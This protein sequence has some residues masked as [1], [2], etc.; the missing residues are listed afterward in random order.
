MHC[1][2]KNPYPPLT[3]FLTPLSL[4]PPASSHPVRYMRF[5]A[6]SPSEKPWRVFWYGID[7]FNASNS[8]PGAFESEDRE[9]YS[10]FRVRAGVRHSC[11]MLKWKALHQCAREC[12]SFCR[13]STFQYSKSCS[14]PVPKPTGRSTRHLTCAC[15]FQSCTDGSTCH[16]SYPALVL[17]PVDS[18]PNP[19]HPR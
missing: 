6:S 18:H 11:A 4:L 14:I 2:L 16:A 3:P 12:V 17:F 1:T 7:T 10:R 19:H 8:E 9:H 13:T 5:K 15:R